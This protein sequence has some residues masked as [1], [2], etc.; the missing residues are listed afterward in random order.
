M[1][2]PRPELV[3]IDLAVNPL[4]ITEQEDDMSA[5]MFLLL[6]YQRL[7]RK[8]TPTLDQLTPVPGRPLNLI[9][10]L[11]VVGVRKNA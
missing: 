9:L 1:A 11:E 3:R 5:A 7:I 6:A 10:T 4:A 8:A 2:K